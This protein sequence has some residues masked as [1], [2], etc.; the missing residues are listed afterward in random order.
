[1]VMPAQI[2]PAFI[3]IEPQLLF[4]LLV[5]L[6][7]SPSHLGKKYKPAKPCLREQIG[8]PIL[9]GLRLPFGPFDEQPLPGRSLFAFSRSVSRKYTDGSKT[10]NESTLGSLAPFD[11]L[12][13]R[14]GK[15]ESKVFNRKDSRFICLVICRL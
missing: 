15:F 9:R 5:A 1:M 8:K 4:E 6:L 7:D 14:G 13:P 10:R 12:P 3:V 11:R 2:A